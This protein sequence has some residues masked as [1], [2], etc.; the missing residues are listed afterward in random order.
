DYWASS[1]VIPYTI[2]E[3]PYW[4]FLYADLHPHL[5]DL[6]VV[7]LIIASCGSL[8]VAT[9]APT[10]VIVPALAVLTLTLGAAGAINTWDL[11]TM[12]VLVVATL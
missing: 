8:L 7:V 1:R 10:R 2:N 11:P 3:F 9:K 5:I 6:A 4:S 12:A